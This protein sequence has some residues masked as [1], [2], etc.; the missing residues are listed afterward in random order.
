MDKSSMLYVGLQGCSTL[1]IPAIRPMQ[2]G[3]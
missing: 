2:P 1:K 3:S